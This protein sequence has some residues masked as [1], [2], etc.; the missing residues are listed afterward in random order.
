MRF[1]I[2]TLF[3]EIL[4]SPLKGSILGKAVEEGKITVR[5]HNLRDFALDKHQVTDDRP[6]GGGF[7]MVMKVEPIC[8]ALEGLEA[9]CPGGWRVLL[10][11]QGV[12]LNQKKVGELAG[13]DHLILICGRYE[14]VDERVREHLI[15]EEISIGD[16]ILSG[17]EPAALVLIDAVSR[18]IP[19]VLGKMGSTQEESFGDDLLEYPHY[20]RPRIFRGWEVPE[21][22]LSGD[23]EHI[24]IW[25][26][27]KSLQRTLQ[28]RPELLAGRTLS[29][30]EQELLSIMQTERKI[31]KE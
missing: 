3:P 2:L 26:K 16:Y 21:I 1:D 22:L 29:E 8:L 25:R 24:R 10:S 23:H 11:P 30:E 15:D 13:K 27:K 12:P 4:V 28:V 18:L 19:G 6:F 17:G 5:L 20:T 9:E 7:G 31:F 14:G